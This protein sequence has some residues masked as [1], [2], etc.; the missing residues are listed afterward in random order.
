MFSFF[1]RGW[2]ESEGGGRRRG[3]RREG[4]SG[5]KGGSMRGSVLFTLC[6][7]MWG[8]EGWEKGFP[9]E[10]RHVSIKMDAP[11]NVTCFPSGGTKR[12][13]CTATV[14]SVRRCL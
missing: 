5:E 12:P 14:R 4:E 6:V 1:V 11:Q 9:S 10:R 3:G 2:W 8:Q 13:L 7:V